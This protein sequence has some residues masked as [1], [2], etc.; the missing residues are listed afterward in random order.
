M[1]AHPQVTRAAVSSIVVCAA[2]LFAAAPAADAAC[3]GGNDCPWTSFS[4]FA[5]APD[6]N[7]TYVALDV[8][9]AGN[10]YT[11]VGGQSGGEVQI[12]DRTGNLKGTW[13]YPGPDFSD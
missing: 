12:F 4:V 3:P 7:H 5:T 10:V 8:D 11:V 9:Q 13:P 2:T 1:R 6:V